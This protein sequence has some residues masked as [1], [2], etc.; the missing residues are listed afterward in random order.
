M[1]AHYAPYQQSAIANRRFWNIVFQY[2]GGYRKSM[3]EV[4]DRRW[5]IADPQRRLPE[6]I[7]TFY[8]RPRLSTAAPVVEYRMSIMH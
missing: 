7:H 1:T 4:G 6:F 5:L 3:L 2:L 8:Q